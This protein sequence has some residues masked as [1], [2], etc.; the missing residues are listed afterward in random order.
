MRHTGRN[1]GFTLIELIVVIA[2]LG[3]LLSIAIPAYRD[4][5][6]KSKVRTAQ[7]DLAALAANV[8]NHLQRKLAYHPDTEVDTAG[9]TGAFPG[10]AP[11]VGADFEFSYTADTPAGGY[12]IT[13]AWKS[14]SN[15]R[16]QGCEVTLDSA[17]VKKL[18]DECGAVMG[19]T[20]W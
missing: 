9:V 11:S 13:A 5:I 16:L 10:W 4:H 1:G 3:I 20:T 18:S 19:A 15:A 6:L 8:E 14:T 2:I 12:T 17:N 7:T